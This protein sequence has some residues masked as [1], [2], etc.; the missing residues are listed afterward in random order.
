MDS[1]EGGAG[2]GVE[3][4]L[5]EERK[6]QKT[7]GTGVCYVPGNGVKK[8]KKILSRVR[9]REDSEKQKN[10]M[11]KRGTKQVAWRGRFEKKKKG[12]TKLPGM[13]PKIN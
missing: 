10:G 12:R 2:G 3:R 9:A 11:E 6:S 8:T 13:W 4:K 7:G 1:F 5:G